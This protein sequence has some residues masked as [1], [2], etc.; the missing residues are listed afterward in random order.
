MTDRNNHLIDKY[1][2]EII[3]MIN[4]KLVHNIF[5]EGNGISIWNYGAIF[6]FKMIFCYNNQWFVLIWTLILAEYSEVSMELFIGNYLCILRIFYN[7]LSFIN[8]HWPSYLVA[9]LLFCQT[10][11]K[12]QM[13]N[14][15]FMITPIYQ[16]IYIQETLM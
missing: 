4:G 13:K 16:K 7:W 1:F 9:G 10:R 15:K 6:N 14:L 12:D 2:I 11:Y 3:Q 5:E 8:H